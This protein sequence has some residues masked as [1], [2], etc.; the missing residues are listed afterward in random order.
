MG[1]V[2][3]IQT[4]QELR[5][6]DGLKVIGPNTLAIAEGGAG[7]LSVISVEGD[8]AHV[9]RVPAGLRLCDNFCA[10][11]GSAWV[12]EGQSDHFGIQLMLGQMLIRPLEL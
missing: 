1:A 5:R 9:Q 2:T 4:S 6:P 7:G 10:P 11:P 12:V 8:T 3:Q